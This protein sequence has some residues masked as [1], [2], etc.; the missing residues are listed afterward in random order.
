MFSKFLK[1]FPVLI[2]AYTLASTGYNN[3]LQAYNHFYRNPLN[4]QKTYG[5]KSHIIITGATEGLGRA[6]ARELAVKGIP[7]I[8]ISENEDSLKK[9]KNELEREFSAK[10]QIIPFDFQTF[11]L[12]NYENLF[13]QLNNYDISGL[14]N[15]V[16]FFLMKD[17]G[18]LTCE[19]IF[20]AIQI[21]ILSNVLLTKYAIDHF[22]IRNTPFKSLVSTTSS[23]FGTYPHPHMSLYSASK[24]F[25]SNFMKSLIIEKQKN[26]DLNLL[27]PG[28]HA[29][30][31]LLETFTPEFV[32]SSYW[33]WFISD[34]AEVAQECMRRFGQEKV[35]YG[36][37]KHWLYH[38][39]LRNYQ[40][41]VNY[42]TEGKIINI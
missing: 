11:S 13:T 30:N 29:N 32:E 10:I 41:T 17:F 35:I 25:N 34:T 22:S 4:I 24:A 15:N 1:S 8:L 20:K 9:V 14:M 26:V 36:T 2:G 37:F 38:G 16:N 39:L 6:F 21:N 3:L 12:S 27:E 23:A 5:D 7:L 33:S 18:R 19:E 28:L 40:K 42:F 31:Q